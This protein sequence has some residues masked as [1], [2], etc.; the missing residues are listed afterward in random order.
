MSRACIIIE[1][2]PEV[3]EHFSSPFKAKT[4]ASAATNLSL[5]ESL[6]TEL[7]FQALHFWDG[8]T[9]A[10]FWHCEEQIWASLFSVVFRG[11]VDASDRRLSTATLG[12]GGCPAA[13]KQGGLSVKKPKV[14]LPEKWFFPHNHC[15]TKAKLCWLLSVDSSSHWQTTA[16]PG[17]LGTLYSGLKLIVHT[18]GVTKK[19]FE[20][21]V[22]VVS[23]KCIPLSAASPVLPCSGWYVQH[24]CSYISVFSFLFS[25]LF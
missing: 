10:W 16:Q 12:A 9:T 22:D 15:D 6:Q 1:G 7:M 4:F 3:M 19:T 8:K 18:E 24:R 20:D 23:P 5:G 11:E 14:H 2:F 13:E 21:A 17:A 25:N